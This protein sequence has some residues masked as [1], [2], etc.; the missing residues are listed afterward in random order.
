MYQANVIPIVNYNS[1]V[2]GYAKYDL[3]LKVQY[4]AIRYFLGLHPKAPLLGLEWDMG[5]ENCRV[6]L[7][8]AIIRLW[9]KL[10]KMNPDRMTKR[11]FIWDYN[12]CKTGVKKS[13]KFLN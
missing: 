1:S 8:W 9:N 11:I 6:R 12:L 2:W 4:R 7:F 10:I 13:N 3:C 5:W